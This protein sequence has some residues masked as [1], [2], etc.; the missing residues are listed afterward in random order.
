[1]YLVTP[2]T[3]NASQADD[4]S[5]AQAFDELVK[6]ATAQGALEDHGVEL[7]GHCVIQPRG[8]E[9]PLGIE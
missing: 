9:V 8:D 6:N 5:V 4:E 7:V 3:Y 1:M 2:V